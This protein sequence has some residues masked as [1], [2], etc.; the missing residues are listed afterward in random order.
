[1]DRRRFLCTMSVSILGAPLAAGAQP[2][3]KV[4]TL[5]I[6]SPH[7]APTPEEIGRGPL[8]VKLS[9]LGWVEGQN[10]KFD[11]AYGEGRE[12]RLPTLA[13]D[14][15]RRRVD[16]IWAL[17][18]PS[19]VAAARATKTIP[20][21]FWG[22][23]YPVELGLVRGLAR[24][25]GNVTGMAHST[26]LELVGKQLEFLRQVAPAATR[27]A[28]IA[29]PDS[30]RTVSGGEY[31]PSVQ[32]S[33]A[34]A[35]GL[36]PRRYDVHRREDFDAVFAAVIAWRAQAVGLTGTPL[37]WRERKRIVEFANRNRLVSTFGMKDFVEVGGLMSYGPDTLETIRQSAVYV[38][39]ILRGAKPA[40]LPVEQ[41]TKFELVINLKTAKALGLTIPPSVLLRADQVIE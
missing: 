8:L 32:L 11:R 16:V 6:L 17:G 18:P 31:T 30:M 36:E 34:R 10:L 15:V 29:N 13:E 12:D 26:G 38:D 37:T 14:L 41:P 28:M 27:V 20:V 1:M 2:A 39:K 21:V 5:G 22:V 23:A 24:P 19:A 9:E 40:D 25:G 7:P 4:Y 33:S 3:G 35:L